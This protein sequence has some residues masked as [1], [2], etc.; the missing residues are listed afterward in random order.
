M[1][2]LRRATQDAAELMHGEDLL[3]ALDTVRNHA[4]GAFTVGDPVAISEAT[5][6]LAAVEIEIKTRG[7]NERGQVGLRRRPIY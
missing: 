2:A 6:A 5:R 3:R 1:I 4:R 7:M